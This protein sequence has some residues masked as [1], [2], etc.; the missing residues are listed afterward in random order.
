M[1]VYSMFIFLT[2]L[3]SQSAPVNVEQGERRG[4]AG[5]CQD[6][7]EVRAGGGGGAELLTQQGG[8]PG[9]HGDPPPEPDQLRHDDGEEDGLH[10][11]P[12][13]SEASVLVD[14]DQPEVHQL[15]ETLID[16]DGIVL[17]VE[18]D[19]GQSDVEEVIVVVESSQ[20]K[21]GQHGAVVVITVNL[22][23][24]VYRAVKITSLE[25]LGVERPLVLRVSLVPVA[26]PGVY[27]D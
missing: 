25:T 12:D 15:A 13:L 11:D 19:R 7:G 6:Q 5:D 23:V 14:G 24:L 21:Q 17:S 10:G 4:E 8:R 27:P 9:Q 1:G 18:I 16:V 22:L 3:S 2:E 20:V 26:Q